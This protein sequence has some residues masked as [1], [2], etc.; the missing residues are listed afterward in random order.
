MHISHIIIILILLLNM[1][2]LVDKLVV[3]YYL[4]FHN[5]NIHAMLNFVIVWLG[6]GVIEKYMME[7]HLQHYSRGL[8]LLGVAVVARPP[9]QMRKIKM[10]VF[11]FQPLQHSDLSKV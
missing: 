6:S 5:P 10:V 2:H 11:V 9:F 4:Y 3:S 7:C 8:F 1:I